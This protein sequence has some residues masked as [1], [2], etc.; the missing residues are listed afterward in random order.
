LDGLPNHPK[1]MRTRGQPTRCWMM[2]NNGRASPNLP[3]KSGS[4]DVVSMCRCTV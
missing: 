2:P 3:I 1:T 4:A